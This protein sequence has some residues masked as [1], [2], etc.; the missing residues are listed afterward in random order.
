MCKW[1][2]SGRVDSFT[3]GFLGFSA[4]SR[5]FLFSSRALNLNLEDTTGH[6]WIMKVE[7]RIS[8]DNSLF[9]LK[10]IIYVQYKAFLSS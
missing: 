1:K 8:E 3:E 2:P 9:K 7:N 5:I 4:P 6:G 10:Q